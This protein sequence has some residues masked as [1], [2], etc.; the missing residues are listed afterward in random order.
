MNFF[1]QTIVVANEYTS[2]NGGSPTTSH[3]IVC[4][5][6]FGKKN[7]ANV[8]VALGNGRVKLQKI[9]TVKMAII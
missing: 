8:R 9:P 5:G 3:N 6:D 7:I 2:K 4:S 1:F